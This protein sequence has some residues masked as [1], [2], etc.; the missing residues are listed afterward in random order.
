MD[1]WLVLGRTFNAG[2]SHSFVVN[3]TGL[4]RHESSKCVSREKTSNDI[5]TESVHGAAV[6][7]IPNS[8]KIGLI[9]TE[10]PFRIN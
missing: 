4:R 8:P 2:A 6:L 3:M 10:R 9:D 5:P 7:I 1:C